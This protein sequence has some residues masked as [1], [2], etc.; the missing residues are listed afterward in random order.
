[1]TAEVA[2]GELWGQWMNCSKISRLRLLKATA[3]Q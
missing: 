3:E 2:L 1:M